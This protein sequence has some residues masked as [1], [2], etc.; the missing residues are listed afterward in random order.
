MTDNVVYIPVAPHWR[1][2]IAH[3]HAQVRHVIRTLVETEHTSIVEVADGE[4]ALVALE[5][6]RFD[7]LVL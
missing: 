6:L 3:Q 7:V 5:R 4:A 2:M 1:L